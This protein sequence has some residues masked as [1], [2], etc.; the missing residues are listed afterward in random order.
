MNQVHYLSILLMLIIVSD[1]TAQDSNLPN[2]FLVKFKP[3]VNAEEVRA[4][5][6]LRND[7]GIREG[8]YFEYLDIWYI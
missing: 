7:N 6:V 2:G 1:V 4:K 8:E 3:S 5:A